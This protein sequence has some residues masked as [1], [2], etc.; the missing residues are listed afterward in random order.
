[1][2]L[3]GVLDLLLAYATAFRAARSLLND[4][5]RMHDKGALAHGGAARG[6]D[7]ACLFS[8]SCGCGP[9]AGFT[10]RSG[11]AF[12]TALQSGDRPQHVVGDARL[13]TRASRRAFR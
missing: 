12:T 13:A 11:E 1:V 4:R 8:I 9:D 10:P 7:P 5:E 3:G 6:P 2:L